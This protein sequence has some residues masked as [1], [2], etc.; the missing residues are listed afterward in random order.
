MSA[1]I[2]PASPDEIAQLPPEQR[3]QLITQA[4]VESKQWLAVATKGTDPTPAAE[5]KAWA[6]TVAEM[7]RQKGLS[8][9]IQM[10]AQEMV[11]RA[12]RGIGQTVR[13]GQATGEIAPNGR[14]PETYPDRKS[15][16]TDFLKPGNEMTETY[17]LTDDV[18]DEQFEKALTEGREEGN[19]SRANVIRKVQGKKL[20]HDASLERRQLIRDLVA[21]NNTSRQIAETLGMRGDS[22]GKLVKAMGLIVPADTVVG[23]RTRRI[24]PERVIS[25]TVAALEGVCSGV[26]LLEPDQLTALDPDM[27]A[28][29][30]SSL[31]D[32][33]KSLNR[34][35]KELDRVRR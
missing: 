10:D 24:D 16:S 18:S 2:E 35:R 9:D 11:R 33:I 28:Q 30:S 34:L 8:K 22:L 1:E 26:A 4:L 17:S 31:A 19:V 20:T 21:R 25:E 27:A 15:S 6:A 23:S 12:E 7:T 14:P 13:N 32:S 5:F 29:W 3:G